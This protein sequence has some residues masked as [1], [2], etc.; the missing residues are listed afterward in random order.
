MSATLTGGLCSAMLF[1][2]VNTTSAW[3]MVPYLA[4]LAFATYLN[5]G[6]ALLNDE[7]SEP[8]QFPSPSP[9]KDT[10]RMLN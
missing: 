8:F 2:D 4:W 7:H 6:T 5:V 10:F 3:L 9:E 1:Q